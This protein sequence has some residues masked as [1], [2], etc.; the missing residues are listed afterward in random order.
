MA[1]KFSVYEGKFVCHKCKAEVHTARYWT[2]EV[3][4]SWK[5]KSCD[6]VS[7]VNLSVR[8]Y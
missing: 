3:E 5:C 6:E 1:K 4:L 8:G 2:R 7:T